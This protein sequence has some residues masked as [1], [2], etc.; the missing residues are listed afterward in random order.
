MMVEQI[1]AVYAIGAVIAAIILGAVED[2]SHDDWAGGWCIAAL[3]PLVFV[4][5]AV[6]VIIGWPFWLGRQ[7]RRLLP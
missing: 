1:A 5:V 4:A 2:R 3:W 7:I 6:C